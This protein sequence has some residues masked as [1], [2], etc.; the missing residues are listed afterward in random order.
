LTI[1]VES[2]AA[3]RSPFVETFDCAFCT[4][5]LAA[6]AF[7]IAGPFGLWQYINRSYLDF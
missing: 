6:F 5:D 1:I 7:Q 2:C 3:F 4:F